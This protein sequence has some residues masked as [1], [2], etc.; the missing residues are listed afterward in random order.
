MAVVVH[1]CGGGQRYA[2]E[3]RSY[4]R[5]LRD[6]DLIFITEAT[7]YREIHSRETMLFAL[8]VC[9]FYGTKHCREMERSPRLTDIPERTTASKLDKSIRSF[10]T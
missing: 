7:T 1:T 3:H 8:V 2:A 6:R 4:K 9:S 5:V 10:G